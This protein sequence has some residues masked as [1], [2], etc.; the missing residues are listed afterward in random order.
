MLYKRDYLMLYYLYFKDF[1]SSLTWHE[2]F[3]K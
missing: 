1:V 2:S 3:I